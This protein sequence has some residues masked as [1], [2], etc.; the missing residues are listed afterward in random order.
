MNHRLP[1]YLGIS[2]LVAG[3]L[4]AAGWMYWESQTSGDAW[5]IDRTEE[6]IADVSP[7]Q[8][9]KIVFRLHNSSR[10]S[11]RIVGSSTC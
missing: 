8:E 2:L 1:H 10:R 9:V 6:M 4:L 11:L 7:G 3:L 5:I